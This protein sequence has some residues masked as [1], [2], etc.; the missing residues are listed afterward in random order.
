MASDEAARAGRAAA[1]AEAEARLA[2]E[3]TFRPRLWAAPS[4][5]RLGAGGGT[6]GRE[7]EA[8]RLADQVLWGRARQVV[9]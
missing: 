4:G 6:S 9:V 2:D 5:A 7:N 8:P 3:C 1:A